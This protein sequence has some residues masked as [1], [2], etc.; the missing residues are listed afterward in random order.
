MRLDISN[1]LLLLTLEIDKTNDFHCA[2]PR[3]GYECVFCNWVP[4]HGECFS[5]VLV[6]VHDREVVN[7]QV[8]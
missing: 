1:E 5:L 8:E 7:S 4:R 2:I 3:A 6:E